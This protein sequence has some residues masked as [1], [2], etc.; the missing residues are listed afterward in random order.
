MEFNAFPDLSPQYFIAHKIAARELVKYCQEFDRWRIRAEPFS[1]GLTQ[2]PRRRGMLVP[3]LA[4][5][6]APP[7]RRSAD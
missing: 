5:R 4:M 2:D 3:H 1:A 7:E 6:Q